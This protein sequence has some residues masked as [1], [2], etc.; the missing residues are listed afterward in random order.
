MVTIYSFLCAFLPCFVYLLIKNRKEKKFYVFFI[1]LFIIYLW[2]VYSVTGAGGLTDIIYAPIGGT[3]DSLI[4]ANINLEPF[5]E[6]VNTTFLLNIV[7]CI[8]LGFLLPLIW[9]NYRNIFKTTLFGLGFSLLIELSQLITTRATDID[10][11]IANT[12]GTI[13]GFIIWITF[14]KILF[15]NKEGI[16]ETKT[17]I[18][19][20]LISYLGMFFLYF[21]FWFAFNIE[22]L[23]L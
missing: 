16:K 14:S 13:I 4:K 6:G 15:K 7:M 21:P 1:I 17:P 12:C 20:V 11:L 18:I 5:R 23:L 9:K 3:N 22:P 10:D 8:P 2:M 19:Y